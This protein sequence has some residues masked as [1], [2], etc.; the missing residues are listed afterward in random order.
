MADINIDHVAFQ[1]ANKKYG[2]VV[3]AIQQTA[4][5][6]GDSVTNAQSGWKGTAYTAF[7]GFHDRLN[8]SIT[9][10]NN[11]L[12]VVNETLNKGNKSY[13][14]TDEDNQSHFTNLG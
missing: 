8:T 3:P 12:N 1:A 11:A 7:A 4:K 6:L 13:N 2:D 10:L 5:S 14:S 9:N